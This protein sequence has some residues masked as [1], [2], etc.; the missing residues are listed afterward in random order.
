[1]NP[2]AGETA[3]KI[4]GAALIAWVIGYPAVLYL[5]HKSLGCVRRMRRVLETHPWRL[6]PHVRRIKGTWEA[7]TAAVHLQYAEHERLTGLMSVWNPVRTYRRW[8]KSMEY[9][10]WYAGDTFNARTAA[11]KRRGVLTL[12]GVGDLLSVTQR[13]GNH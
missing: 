13:P 8:P 10:A 2:D 7:Y 3:N 5:S 6:V 11:S 4:G 9:G 1:M 12:P